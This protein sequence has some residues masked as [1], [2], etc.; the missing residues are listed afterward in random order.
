MNLATAITTALEYHRY[1]EDKA[2]HPF[3]GHPLRVMAYAAEETH[4]EELLCAAVL[5]DVVEDSP[6]TIEDLNVLGFSQ[7]VQDLV[8]ILTRDDDAETYFEYI[9]RVAVGGSDAIMLKLSDLRDNL[10]QRRGKF[11]G[12]ESIDARHLKAQT[13]L[14]EIREAIAV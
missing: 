9:E 7:R 8:G 2:G 13:R 4:D 1:Q 5:H 6:C 11:E 12:R 10:D 3:V 14:I